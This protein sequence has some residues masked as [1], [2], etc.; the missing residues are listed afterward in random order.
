MD[1][2]MYTLLKLALSWYTFSALGILKGGFG[3][4]LEN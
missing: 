2:E 4:E 3:I 1:L